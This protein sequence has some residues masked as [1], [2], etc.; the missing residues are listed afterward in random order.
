MCAAC[1]IKL[2]DIQ[3]TVNEISQMTAKKDLEKQVFIAAREQ[4][5]SSVLFRNALGR[6]L[7]LNVTDGECLSLLSLK[8]TSTPTELARYTGLTTGS[9]TAMLDRLEKAKFI[10]R[11]PNPNDRRGVLI[12][13]NEQWAEKA[14]P[15][16]AGV[17]KAHKELIASYSEQELEAIADFLTRFA[18][19]VKDQTEKIEKNLI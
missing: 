8:G 3:A 7:G 17:Q 11:K 16:V 18:K 5:I 9:T 14:G 6:R 4:G 10:R 2:L 19:N 1:I 13:I 15:L 12:E